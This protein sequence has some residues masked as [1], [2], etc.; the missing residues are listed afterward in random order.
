M[1]RRKS[2]APYGYTKS[3]RVRTR[4]TKSQR[5]AHRPARTRKYNSAKP[6]YVK[7]RG[8]YNM[9]PIEIMRDPLKPL[10][11]YTAG[12]ARRVGGAV[13]GLGGALAGT[14]AAGP[15]GSVGGA[16]F[17]R[18]LGRGLGQLVGDVTGFGDYKLGA[19]RRSNA[20]G[21][22][23]YGGSGRSGFH[24]REKRSS[25]V[26]LFGSTVTR[27][28]NRE[29]VGMVNM[30]Q[31]FTNNA[32]SLNP[33]LETTF[34]RLSQLARMFEQ[35][36]FNGLF[37]EY[38]PFSATSVTTTNL[39]IGQVMMATDYD[40]NDVPF[41]NEVELLSSQFSNVGRVYDKFKHAVECKKSLQADNWYFVRTENTDAPDSLVGYDLGKFQLATI[42][43]QADFD[44]AGQLWVSYDVTFQNP[45]YHAV[46]SGPVGSQWTGTGCTNL[47][48][49]GS[50]GSFQRKN[51]DVEITAAQIIFGDNAPAGTYT[52]AY[53]DPGA[54]TAVT[55]TW[56][57][58][59]CT[60]GANRT[61]SGETVTKL[62]SVQTIT[63]PAFT[64][65]SR[66]MTCTAATLP[67][68]GSI[69]EIFIS[70]LPSELAE[71]KPGMHVFRSV[72]PVDEYEA[73]EKQKQQARLQKYL[74]D[75]G[76]ASDSDDE[77]EQVKAALKAAKL[78]GTPHK[79]N[80]K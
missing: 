49:L 27:Y 20:G 17:G 18:G 9:R 32:F 6:A 38:V 43:G 3:G 37:F 61:N 75:K 70:K 23:V 31:L 66:L 41:D 63:L 78:V 79:S 8:D 76:E 51:L 58:T 62:F 53:Y 5:A 26:P 47:D 48:P 39:A 44:N 50:A 28:R 69:C 1:Y 11:P 2:H 24:G 74:E 55:L 14:A 72:I 13:G 54:S 16:A 33:G 42:G 65:S 21:A 64:G 7:G 45:I 40:V 10:R 77:I 22:R 29:M 30:T 46:D 52:V 59:N 34:P 15:F 73:N 56:S 57:Y 60:L 25:G 36:R 35:Y 80:K 68:G 19:R 4:P 71:E 67:T 12:I